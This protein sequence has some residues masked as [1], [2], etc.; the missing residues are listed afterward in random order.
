M[1]IDN[2]SVLEIDDANK[3]LF[4]KLTDNKPFFVS[5]IGLGELTRINIFLNG[6]SLRQRIRH[7]RGLGIRDSL[8]FD[9]RWKKFAPLYYQ[10]YLA[11][12]VQCVWM[13]TEYIEMQSNLLARCSKDVVA[14]DARSIE[15]YYSKYPWTAALEGKKVLVVSPFIDDFTRQYNRQRQK[16][17][18]INRK[19]LPEFELLCYK[20]E[21][22]FNKTDDYAGIYHK[23]SED[24][25]GFD[26]DIA[27]LSCGAVGLPLGR[28]IRE[29]LH[30][31]SVYMGGALQILFGVKGARWEAHP[32]ISA[33]FNE[34]WIYPS[35]D[36][37]TGGRAL[38]NSCYW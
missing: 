26:F 12:D 11:G 34:S 31:S 6:Y 19:I 3:Y 32:V 16:I 8:S 25:S 28:Y 23:M 35:S 2:R 33:F 27:L 1:E 22:Y 30:K 24:V 29:D 36:P 38:D 15:P 13:S 9:R 37:S 7:I 4:E 20:S 5:R 10:A 18:P 17:W 21:F 14:M